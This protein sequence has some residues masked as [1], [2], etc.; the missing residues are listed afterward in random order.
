MV[1]HHKNVIKHRENS[2][3]SRLILF[4]CKNKTVDKIEF[5]TVISC[6]RKKNDLL[7]S[8]RINSEKNMLCISKRVEKKLIFIQ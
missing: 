8:N 5:L 1:Q 7:L 4:K 2:Y 3:P 6:K